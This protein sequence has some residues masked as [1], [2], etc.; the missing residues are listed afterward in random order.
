MTLLGRSKTS[1][2]VPDSSSDMMAA[3]V[4]PMVA[5]V[6]A[7]AITMVMIPMVVIPMVVITMVVIPMV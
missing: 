2:F 6:V 5:L 1:A 3:T 7:M 4:I